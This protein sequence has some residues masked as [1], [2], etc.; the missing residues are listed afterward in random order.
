MADE[1]TAWFRDLFFDINEYHGHALYYDVLTPWAE[2]AQSAIAEFARFKQLS[3][4]DSKDE[5][6]PVVM[7][8]LY[9]LSRANDLLLLQ[10][11]GNGRKA[12][13]GPRLHPHE[14]VE[15]FTQLGFEIAGPE[16]FSPVH[17]EI[18]RVHQ[19]SNDE[20]PIGVL[21]T[22]WPGLMYGDMLFSRSGVAAIGGQKRVV[23]EVAENSTLYFAFR[24]LQRP[25]ND[26]S[27]GWGSNS[28][29][30]TSFRRDYR[31]AGTLVY[32]ADGKNRLNADPTSEN[33]RNGLTPEQRIELCQNRCFIVTSKEH[34]DL[35]PFDDRYE[36]PVWS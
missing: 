4:F 10:F 22:L 5:D 3:A 12:W 29:W 7:W 23:K 13:E 36:E 15:F 21:E 1:S 27:A 25:T 19:S 33:D 26:L 11:Q 14:Y 2:K 16:R 20:E 8:N 31:S 17:H 24:R 9:A 6:A 35:W 30:R 32:N 18:V 28:Q 34:H